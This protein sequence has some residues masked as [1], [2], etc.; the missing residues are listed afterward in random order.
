MSEYA[1]WTIRVGTKQIQRNM[2]GE[3]VL[4]V[5]KGSHFNRGRGLRG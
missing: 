1:S 3:P 4:G 2:I 5:P